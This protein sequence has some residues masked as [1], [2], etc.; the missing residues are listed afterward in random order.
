MIKAVIFDLDNTLTDFLETKRVCIDAAIKAMIKEG[1]KVK[2][3]QGIKMLYTLY[4]KHGMEDEIIFQRFLR[5]TIKKVDYNLLAKAINAYR[6]AR[7]IKAYPHTESTLKALKKRRLK[8]AVLTDAPRLKAYL[9]LTAMGIEKYFDTILTHDDT[10]KKKPSKI[11]FRKVLA[12]LKTK[13]EETLMVG[14]FPR[15]DIAGAK[16]MKIKTCF[17]KYGYVGK[18]KVKAD[19]V[20]DDIKELS[21]IV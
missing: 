8:L 13:P 5:K 18:K 4:K 17:A 12:K 3:E 16:R 10:K 1:L 9:R 11:P 19:F 15:G 14:D 20:I 2:K 21:G 6:K 7:V